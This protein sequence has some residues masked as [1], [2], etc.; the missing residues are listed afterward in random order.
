[1]L[2]HPRLPATLRSG[3]WLA[4]A[5][6]LSLPVFAQQSRFEIVKGG[7]VVGSI[8]AQ[9][10]AI[11]ERT[12]YSM[13]SFSEFNL[14]FDQVVR[15]SVTTEYRGALMHNCQ[16]HVTVNGSLRDSSHCAPV[17]DT[18]HCYVHPGKRFVEHQPVHWTTARM[19]FE[20]PVDQ[21]AIF[22][23]SVLRHCPLER[24]GPG[25]YKLVLPG[26]K[27][28]RYTYRDGRLEAVHVDRGLFTLLFRNVG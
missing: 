25:E 10:T 24:T 28:N 23:E 26:N 16:S 12:R 4:L 17:A 22:V 9:R 20:E 21:P 5:S 2:L 3:C 13:I 18:T 7:H 15:S 19:Y 6:V 27:V 8:V 11:G 14:V 1:M